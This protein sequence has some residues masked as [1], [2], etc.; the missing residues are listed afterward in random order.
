VDGENTFRD[1]SR[2]LGR[3][4]GRALG[5]NRFVRAGFTAA[6]GTLQSFGRVLHTLWLEV[7]GLFFLLFAVIGTAALVREYQAY[8]AGRADINKV[9]AAALFTV[10]FAYFGVSSFWRSRRKRK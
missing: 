5:N 8:S 3:M 6:Q 2:A 4:G 9:V 10:I 7:T 1:A